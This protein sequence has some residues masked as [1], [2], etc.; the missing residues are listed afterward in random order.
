MIVMVPNHTH[1]KH[2]SSSNWSKVRNDT[3]LLQPFPL[4]IRIDKPASFR[5]IVPGVEVVEPGL[6]IVVIPPVAERIEGT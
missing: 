3:N 4:L 2:E 5:I 6:L 1:I